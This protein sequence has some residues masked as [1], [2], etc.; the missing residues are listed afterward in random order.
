[1]RADYIL[2]GFV[3]V[4]F[5]L[6]PY[7]TNCSRCHS[8]CVT[9]E[10]FSS[11]P[12]SNQHFHHVVRLSA[13][14]PEFPNF[15][16]GTSEMDELEKEVYATT[17]VKLDLKRVVEGA[18]L[19]DD[20][21]GDGNN[22]SL[23]SAGAL[24]PSRT[25]V[26]R[27]PA[28]DPKRVALLASPWQIALASASAVSAF[29]LASTS[30]NLS[31]AGVVFLAVFVIANG[32]PLEE[33]GAAGALARLLG[34]MTIQSVESSKPKLKAIAR[35]A[36]TSEEDILLLRQRNQALEEENAKLVLWKEQRIA[37]EES[38]SKYSMDELK[39]LARTKK[40]PLAGTKSQLLM[41]LV[42]SQVI[43]IL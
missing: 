18:A 3:F 21:D 38:L 42:E 5:H 32:D 39:E 27:I 4:H 15:F 43:D 31:I 24:L 9:V 22:P 28:D 26:D 40:I 17:R 14:W 35:A 20:I 25:G 13:K 6:T 10:A 8:N 29:V 19:F 36:I 1:M 33:E 2:V 11:P 12:T 30:A 34:R 16:S 37:V 41:R 7:L 23:L